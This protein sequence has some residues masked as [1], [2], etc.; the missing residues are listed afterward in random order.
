MT[1]V[2]KFSA[3]FV[4]RRAADLTD[5][6]DPAW[7]WLLRFSWWGDLPTQ[8]DPE[9]PTNPVLPEKSIFAEVPV[10]KGRRSPAGFV[11]RRFRAGQNQS[12]GFPGTND[13]DYYAP[14][15]IFTKH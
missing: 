8:C 7:C 12:L 3:V 9:T 4:R 10:P 13:T 2:D 1:M 14:R 6:K 15:A 11:H 5:V